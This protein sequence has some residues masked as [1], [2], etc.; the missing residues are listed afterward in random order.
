MELSARLPAD[1]ADPATHPAVWSGSRVAGLLH[2][3]PWL[4]GLPRDVGV[5]AAI[6]FCVALGFGI[7]APALPVFA[8][9][10]GVS[11][12]LAGAVISVF[13]LMRLIG[14][15]IAGGMVNRIGERSVLAAGLIIVGASSF[16]AGLSQSYV[17][18]LLLRGAGGVGSAMFTVSALALLLRT[19][20]P[21]QRG[22]AA[23]A[24]QAGFLFGAITGPAVG[25]LVV[26]ISIRAPFF[27]YAATLAL[28]TV[29]C[30]AFLRSPENTAAQSENDAGDRAP[31]D[32][33]E[34]RVPDQGLVPAADPQDDHHAD[35][36][37]IPAG[38]EQDD[39]RATLGRA[40][41][42]GG[43]RAAL[44]ANLANGV[45][46][47]GIRSSLVPLFVVE[48]L[49]RGPGLAGAGFLVGALLQAIVLL[50]AGKL[51]DQR[52]R[53][54][55]IIIGAAATLVGMA[56]LTAAS[57]QIVFLISMGVLGVGTAFLGS[58]PSAVV[59]DVMGNHRGGTVVATYQ[60]IADVGA[61]TGPLLAG[62]IA[63]RAGY[64][65]AFTPAL[66]AS[67]IA[68][69]FALAMP[70]TKLGTPSAAHP[71]PAS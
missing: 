63:D 41:R 66:A 70:E 2:R 43:Y 44:V 48:S 13:A 8:R 25:G 15:P 23:G 24:F 69:A 61:I 18:L 27:L 47:F 71:S 58:A 52:G 57:E 38:D 42:N 16:V 14:A 64:H 20:G 53:R 11:A 35:K 21:H 31:L 32:P 39:H 12:L 3:T 29:V 67:L 4:A 56:L 36:G 65:W 19:A 55:A 54:P 9:T 34:G 6:A 49:H 50:P 60:M 28:A 30:L 68:L 37:P 33:D 45:V 62:L 40:L 26:G 5:L 7:V 17:Q 22:R 46:T 1:V 10:F 59:G 51:A